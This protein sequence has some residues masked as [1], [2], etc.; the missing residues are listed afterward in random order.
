M[1]CQRAAD[2]CQSPAARS[3]ITI[4]AA[5]ARAATRTRR[6]PVPTCRGR[7]KA[8]Q[9]SLQ[10]SCTAENLGR[11]P[12]TGKQPGTGAQCRP[13]SIQALS[14]HCVYYPVLAFTNLAIGLNNRTYIMRR[15]Q[16][17]CEIAEYSNGDVWPRPVMTQ[18]SSETLSKDFL[19]ICR[20]LGS[21]SRSV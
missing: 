4:A 11:L 14:G 12:S 8:L 2:S 6:H 15:D 7:T 5:L 1:V 20:K 9:C 3:H 21:P 16:D 19:L 10:G 18:S 17:Q 13:C